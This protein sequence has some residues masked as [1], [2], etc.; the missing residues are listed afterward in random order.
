MLNYCV[1]WLDID[2][3]VR[4]VMQCTVGNVARGDGGGRGG[5]GGSGDCNVTCSARISK[6]R[7]WEVN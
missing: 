2:M 5:G 7:Q 3:Y 6:R 4:S 1:T